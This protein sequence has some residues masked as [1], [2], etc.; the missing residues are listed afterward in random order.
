VDRVPWLPNVARGGR[1]KTGLVAVVVAAV[2]VA[3][4]GTAVFVFPG[5]AGSPS[6][7]V[8]VC[9]HHNGLRVVVDEPAWEQSL[10]WTE[11]YLAAAESSGR[12]TLATGAT[13]V[14]IAALAAHAGNPVSDLTPL[15]DELAAICRSEGG[16]AAWAADFT[17]VW[18][19]TAARCDRGPEFIE[20]LL[21]GSTP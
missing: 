2:L 17:P 4:V 13:A 18:H 7:L 11:S 3:G 21:E 10:D 6:G 5:T 9:A 14:R 20:E 12:D 8:R 19:C 16:D 15:V 1:P